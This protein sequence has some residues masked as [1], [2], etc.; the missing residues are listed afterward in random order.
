V[1]VHYN[2]CL[3]NIYTN[4]TENTPGRIIIHISNIAATS[5][6]IA[7]LFTLGCSNSTI[8]YMPKLSGIPYLKISSDS[9]SSSPSSDI[10]LIIQQMISVM[11]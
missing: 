3:I 7:S 1:E 6:T 10:S 11:H 8:N 2:E 5:F 9:F 4:I